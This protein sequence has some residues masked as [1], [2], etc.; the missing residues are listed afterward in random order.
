M[1]RHTSSFLAK[2]RRGAYLVAFALALIPANNIEL[3]GQSAR[4]I[5]LQL[6]DGSVQGAL[7]TDVTLRGTVTD[8]FGTAK[9][10][11]VRI[12]G[13]DKIR[14]EIGTG[15][16]RRVTV[17]NANEGW[18]QVGTKLQALPQHSSV[19]RPSLIPILDLVGEASNPRLQVVDRGMKSI[20]QRTV[21]QV[22]LSL[23]DLQTTRSFGRKLD[24]N[25]D[26]FIDPSTLLVVR[27]Q[28]FLRSQEN[29]DLPVPSVLEFSDYRRVGN[30]AVPFR[31]VNTTGTQ[32][33]GLH[34]KTFV[35]TEAVLNT[36]VADSNFRAGGTQ[37]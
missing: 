24:E 21:Q 14:F 25:L 27:T 16:N 2:V 6:R 37:Q 29:M 8:E 35:I 31:I 15:P 18:T 33:G 13:T 34:Q 5:V 4:D 11:L 12:K 30:L 10:L 17:F 36:N 28:R 1:K 32:Q 26:V 20:G 3:A 9:P 22:S 19:R 23:P 7:P